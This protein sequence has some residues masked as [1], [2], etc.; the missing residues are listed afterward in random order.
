MND[1]SYHLIGNDAGMA[2]IQFFVTLV[3]DAYQA[4]QK[5]T[6]KPTTE[7]DSEPESSKEKTKE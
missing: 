3:V 2:S 6:P 1:V 5:Q 7:D 4:G